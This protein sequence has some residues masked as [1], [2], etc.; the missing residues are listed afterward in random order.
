ME[1]R[2]IEQGIAQRL[3]RTKK[4][5]ILFSDDFLDLGSSPSINRALSRLHQKGILVRIAQGLYLYPK[6][7]KY[8]GVTFPSLDEIAQA[9]A[10][11]DK[12]RIIPTGVQ[13][14]NRLGL[15]TQIPMKMI[16][17]TDGTPRSVQIGKRSVRFKTTTP[18]NLS[19]KGE[20]TTLVI[21]ALREIG[22]ENLQLDERQ[23]IY[24]LLK[25]EDPHILKHDA[26]LAPAWIREILLEVAENNN[27]L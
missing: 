26:K 12:A 7:D 27:D 17:L 19:V 23:K 8:L 1:R 11:R 3:K 21:Q 14:L 5:S 4:G 25:K 18:K 16:Y 9:I 13:A 10:E 15:S 20:I 22:K 24:Q 6:K 2:K